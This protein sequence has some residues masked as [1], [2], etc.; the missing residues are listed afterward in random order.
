MKCITQSLK[1][2]T[3]SLVDAPIPTPLE[4]QLIIETTYSVISSGTEKMLID[5]GK[6]NPI[7]KIKKQPDKFKEVINK[8]KTDGLA[9]TYDAVKSKLDNPIYPGYSNVGKVVAIGPNVKGFQIGDRVVS[10]GPH[11]EFVA[12]KQN[13]CAIVP[14]SLTDKEA[15]F[16]VLTSIGLQGTRLAKP[17]FGETFL[18]VGLGLI[19]LL[20]CQILKSQGVNVIG[21]DP[22]RKKC[23]LAEKIGV[24]VILYLVLLSIL[25][26]L[27]MKKIWSRVNPEV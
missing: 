20:T 26:F 3:I 15:S 8:V 4:G 21:L 25:V 23:N 2:G 1:T 10:N 22:D 18:V 19:G 11:A 5:F 17:C 27:S 12:V 6:S 7:D 24:K 9:V 14:D 16:T 13:L